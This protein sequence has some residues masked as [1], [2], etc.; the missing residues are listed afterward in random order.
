MGKLHTFP[1]HRWRQ[2]M[3][4]RRASMLP[5]AAS[6]QRKADGD[7]ATDADAAVLYLEAVVT[8]AFEATAGEISVELAGR[9]LLAE[10]VLYILT[11]S[12]DIDDV[13]HWIEVRGLE[14]LKR[15]RS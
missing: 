10:D 13:R 5:T 8:A 14:R 9:C 4:S 1:V 3:D 11:G 6:I 15:R 12:S 2:G 7:E